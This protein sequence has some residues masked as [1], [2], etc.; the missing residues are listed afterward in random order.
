MGML[1]RWVSAHWTLQLTAG[2]RCGEHE[3]LIH[4]SA[5]HVFSRFGL[6]RGAD[7]EEEMKR[8]KESGVDGGGKEEI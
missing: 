8:G 1:L 3:C 2:M 4:S 7:R 6:E 5:A